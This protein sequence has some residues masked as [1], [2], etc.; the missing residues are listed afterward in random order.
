MKLKFEI[1]TEAGNLYVQREE[2]DPKAQASGFTRHEHGWG[3]EIH[4]LHLMRVALNKMGF[5]L[6]SIKVSKD[7]HMFGDN[8]MRYLRTPKSALRKSAVPFPYMYVYDGN[9]A[10]RSSAE[11]YNKGEEIRFAVAGH[12]FDDYP[13][14]HWWMIVK[15]LCEQHD[16]PCGLFGD[17]KEFQ[18]VTVHY[19][20][21][22]YGYQVLV[23]KDGKIVKEY[24]AG[25]SRHESQSYVEPGS[26]NAESPATLAKFA[27]QTAEEFAKEYGGCPVE[28]D[29]D[30]ESGLAEELEVFV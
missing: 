7:G 29:T 4:L 6:S 26:M 23:C 15:E 24:S 27:K 19:G 22:P 17:A 9:Y 16:I 5:N 1:G 10:I 13:Q 30:I 3:A 14:P 25:N 2:G 21:C 8:F 28:H 12:P 11:A 18:G 20:S